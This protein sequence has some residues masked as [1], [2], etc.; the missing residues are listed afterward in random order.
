MNLILSPG[1]KLH[2]TL[3]GS[4]VNFDSILTDL[5]EGRIHHAAPVAGKAISL[6]DN[7]DGTLTLSAT[8]AGDYDGNG[9]INGDDTSTAAEARTH[10]GPGFAHRIE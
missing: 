6:V 3:A 7:S 8:I 5:S 10:S 2:I 9:I 4:T 1:D